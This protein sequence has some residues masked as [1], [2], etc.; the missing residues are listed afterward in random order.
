MI[1][2]FK[3]ELVGTYIGLFQVIESK[4]ITRRNVLFKEAKQKLKKSPE[5]VPSSINC[6]TAL[7]INWNYWKRET[8]IYILFNKTVIKRTETVTT[9]VL[10]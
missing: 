6:K 2:I 4:Q 5:K 1:F 8:K 10:I 9:N 7:D 3:T